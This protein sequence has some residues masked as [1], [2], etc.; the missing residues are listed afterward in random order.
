MKL[1][2]DDIYVEDAFKST[3]P[4]MYNFCK[5]TLNNE[6]SEW[7]FSQC[8]YIDD[9]EIEVGYVNNNHE[10]RSAIFLFDKFQHIKEMDVN[11]I[12]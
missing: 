1:I 11:N 4:K 8:C 6:G 12:D 7:Y 5:K 9:N 2:N 3:Y 10:N